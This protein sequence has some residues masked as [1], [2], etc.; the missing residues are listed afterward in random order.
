MN[1]IVKMKNVYG[2]NLV[3]PVNDTAILFG[4]LIGKQ[5]FN[6]N[7]LDNIRALNFKIIFDNN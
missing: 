7:D 1:V 4:R 2:N 5:T 6:A 3:Y